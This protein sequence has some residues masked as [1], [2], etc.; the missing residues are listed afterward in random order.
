MS[1]SVRFSSRVMSVGMLGLIVSIGCSQPTASRSAS[2]TAPSALPEGLNVKPGATRDL[3]GTWDLLE[4]LRNGDESHGVI[5]IVAG[6]NE[7]TFIGTGDGD[8][9]TF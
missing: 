7:N 2:L 4:R 9:Y 1:L 5:N 3:I 8:T 6:G